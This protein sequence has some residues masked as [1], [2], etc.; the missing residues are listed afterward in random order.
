[1]TQTK[2][3][4]LHVSYNLKEEKNGLK[5][6]STLLFWSLI[7][8]KTFLMQGPASSEKVR[9]LCKIIFSRG[10]KFQFSFQQTGTK[11]FF[12]HANFTLSA[13]WFFKICHWNSRIEQSAIYWRQTVAIFPL[14][15][16]IVNNNLQSEEIGPGSTEVTLH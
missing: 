3:F 11:E 6:I 9:S 12:V 4:P 2:V 13:T 15:E 14:S 5:N 1:M 7:L 8:N 10:P 16:R